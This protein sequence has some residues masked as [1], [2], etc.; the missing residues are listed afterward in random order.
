MFE[1]NNVKPDE[2]INRVKSHYNES[3]LESNKNL[4][5]VIPLVE[6]CD[7]KE[8]AIKLY[9]Y[10]YNLHENLSNKGYSGNDI[11]SMLNENYTIKFL[12]NLLEDIEEVFDIN[13][14]FLDKFS[15]VKNF[16]ERKMKGFSTGELDH[17][18]RK[19]SNLST[20]KEKV[21]V[22]EEIKDALY[23]AR[24]KLS[25]LEHTEKT[26]QVERKIDGLKYHIEALNKI[27]MKAQSINII[28]NA[29]DRGRSHIDHDS[30]SE[31]GKILH[32]G[33]SDKTIINIDE[34]YLLSF[35]LMLSA[36]PLVET[37]TSSQILQEYF[38]A[39]DVSIDKW[40]RENKGAIDTF[41]KGTYT[42]LGG[43]FP[44]LTKDRMGLLNF[45]THLMNVLSHIRTKDEKKRYLE[46]I[47]I[48]IEQLKKFD[49]TDKSFF[50]LDGLLRLDDLAHLVKS[51]LGSVGISYLSTIASKLFTSVASAFAISG[52]YLGVG[53]AAGGKLAALGKILS[54][55][56]IIFPVVSMLG[57]LMWAS[58]VR[59]DRVVNLIKVLN[60]FKTS[61]EE[62]K[63][64]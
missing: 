10:I 51:T 56:S 39:D 2:L 4:T 7:D 6:N 38:N 49:R 29:I 11:Q 14:G 60:D 47:D 19:A 17:L 32:K 55:A 28:D 37:I 62:L 41:I 18:I 23:S 31:G 1:I 64:E 25:D 33:G 22:L 3:L 46:Q 45:R 40:E 35:P 20:E 24:D 58:H 48:E 53:A 54:T 63:V 27:K 36:I 50:S 21:E 12:G 52:K 57:G 42:E 8:K 34:E 61:V 15:E 9:N 59:S 13:E 5:Y 30:S 16:I 44:T 43:I 26:P